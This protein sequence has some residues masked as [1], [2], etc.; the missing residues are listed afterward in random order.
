MTYIL[1]SSYVFW[2][3]SQIK[4]LWEALEKKVLK[5]KNEWNFTIFSVTGIINLCTFLQLIKHLNR[6]G[7]YIDIEATCFNITDFSFRTQS[8][9][10]ALSVW[11]R[12]KHG[13]RT[14]MFFVIAIVRN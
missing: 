12:S 14:Q 9:H 1:Y 5:E 4:P 13:L 8:T 3:Q 2:K 10:R 6:T 11:S 7:F